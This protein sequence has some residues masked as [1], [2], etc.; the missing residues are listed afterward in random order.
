MRL[1]TLLALISPIALANNIEQSLLDCRQQQDSLKRLM[2]YDQINSNHTETST[3]TLNNSNPVSSYGLKQKPAEAV[4][5]IAAK[6]VKQK[7]N[8][9]GY[10]I[11]TLDN[12]Q[13]WQQK[14]KA[15][16]KLD[17]TKNVIISDGAL[18]SFWLSQEGIN[19]RTRV[20]RIK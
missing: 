2:C 13:I 20:K 3:T 9:Y 4:D 12:G 17:H 14:E 10:Y 7:K 5:Q 15:Y 1:I 8:A 16:L 11:W 6:V 18:G 19:K